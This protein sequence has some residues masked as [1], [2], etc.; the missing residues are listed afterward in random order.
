VI[1]VVDERVARFVG[2][3]VDRIIYPPF[4]CMGIERDGEVIGGVVF[5]C[6]TGHDIH[7]TVA[8]SGWTKGFLADVGQ[9]LFG[10]LKVGR[11]TVVTE[12]VKVVRL[13]E[14][15]GGQIEGCLRNHFGPGRD[16][17]V[18]GILASEWK[19]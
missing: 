18:C 19:Y 5:N 13:A 16:G 3:R 10:A 6:Y 2:Q 17:Y 4:T 1:I 12:Q 15:L 14:R 8:G 11:V 7:V 9:Y